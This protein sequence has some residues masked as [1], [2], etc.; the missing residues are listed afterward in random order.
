MRDV[1]N[2]ALRKV[3]GIRRTPTA[4][5]MEF[6]VET[7]NDMLASWRLE[8]LDVGLA[9]ELEAAD[10]LTLPESYFHAI[11][12]A[13][14]VELADQFDR[15]LTAALVTSALN[16]KRALLNSL[17]EWNDLGFEGT[18]VAPRPMRSIDDI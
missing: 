16:A 15:P 8:G 17:T 3:V 18:L 2:S 7:L 1:C 13:M 6:A 9:G 14:Q 12:L 4:I 5:E 10:T 11:K